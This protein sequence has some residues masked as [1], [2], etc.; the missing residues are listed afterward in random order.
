MNNGI[1]DFSF[2]NKDDC[3]L[4]VVAHATFVEWK[5]KSINGKIERAENCSTNLIEAEC[6]LLINFLN[7]DIMDDENTIKKVERYIIKNEK[8]YRE[9]EDIT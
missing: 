2:H 3:I 4:I 6:K 9:E 1:I 5:M 8:F 7:L